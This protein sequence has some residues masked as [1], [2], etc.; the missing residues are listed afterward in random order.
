LV[1]RLDIRK[2]LGHPIRGGSRRG[3]AFQKHPQ[4][5]K[6]TC[7]GICEFGG[8]LLANHAPDW[9]SDDRATSR[10]CLENAA[11]NAPASSR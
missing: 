1:G 3:F 6:V 5:T 9:C 11:D 2:L 7:G 10:R 4:L 8:E